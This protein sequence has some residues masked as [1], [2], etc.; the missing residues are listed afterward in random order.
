MKEA[1]EVKHEMEKRAK[2]LL[3]KIKK[4]GELVS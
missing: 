2:N 1:M 4:V 3:L